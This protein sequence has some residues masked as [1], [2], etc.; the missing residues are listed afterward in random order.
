MGEVLLH[1]GMSSSPFNE[2]VKN[3]DE[4]R[5]SSATYTDD[6]SLGFTG[7]ANARYWVEL[8]IEYDRGTGGCKTQMSAPS[9]VSYEMEVS[10]DNGGTTAHPTVTTT[11]TTMSI[12]ADANTSGRAW[13]RAAGFVNMPASG[14]RVGLQWAQNSSNAA[15]STMLG[16]SFMRYKKVA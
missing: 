7:E 13:A 5:S 3:A 2:V 9:G 14:G 15:A 11:A 6:A 8:W 10:I 12:T 1:G 16:G 4:P